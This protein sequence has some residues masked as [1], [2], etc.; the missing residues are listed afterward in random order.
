[1]LPPKSAV[2]SPHFTPPRQ[3]KGCEG[4][5]PPSVDAGAGMV[6]PHNEDATWEDHM[7]TI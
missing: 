6:A 5:Q 1:M 7:E 3:G 2:G 4:S